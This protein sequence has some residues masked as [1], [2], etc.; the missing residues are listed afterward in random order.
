[1]QQLQLIRHLHLFFAFVR[2]DHDSRSV[3]K[4][5]SHLKSC[6]WVLSTTKCTFPDL[7]DSVVGISSIIVGIHDS[8]QS[9][10]EPLAFCFP[11]SPKPL[12][13][14]AYIW[15]PFNKREYSVS[16]SMNNDYFAADIGTGLVATPP[17]ESVLASHPEKSKLMYYLH[18]RGADATVLVGAAVFPLDSLCPPFDGSPNS[19]IFRDWFGI[20][21]HADDHTHVRAI[22]PFEFTS[23]FG[24]LD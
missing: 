12:P 17:S 3:S 22:S 16:L 19:N 8:T 1:V 15:P 11:P 6:G 20:E 13:L 5:T 10:V 7:G 9:R 2:P 23:C 4:F 21:F 14:A 18:T 24:L